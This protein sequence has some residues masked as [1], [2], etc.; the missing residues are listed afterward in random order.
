MKRRDLL[1]GAIV[2]PFLPRHL[3][4]VK[5]RK[6]PVFQTRGCYFDPGLGIYPPVHP[7]CLCTLTIEEKSFVTVGKV[8]IDGRR[9]R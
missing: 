3:T 8:W 2:L 5:K 9:V 7:N 1:E 4:V 6:I